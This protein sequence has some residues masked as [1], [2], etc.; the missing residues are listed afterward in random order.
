MISFAKLWDIF[1]KKMLLTA[2]RTFARPQ[3]LLPRKMPLTASINFAQKNAADRHDYF[4]PKKDA[5]RLEYFYQKK[6][7]FV[8][9]NFNFFKNYISTLF[10]KISDVQVQTLLYLTDA[11]FLPKNTFILGSETFRQLEKNLSQNNQLYPSKSHFCPV[12]VVQSGRNFV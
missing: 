3:E 10:F 2:T 4:C 12:Y 1:P 5:S 11:Y 6:C 7:I 8:S 9:F